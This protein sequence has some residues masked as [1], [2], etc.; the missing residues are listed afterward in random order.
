MSLMFLNCKFV[1]FWINPCNKQSL[2]YNYDPSFAVNFI[3]H[4]VV[5]AT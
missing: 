4:F 1:R 3:E 5:P 2:Q